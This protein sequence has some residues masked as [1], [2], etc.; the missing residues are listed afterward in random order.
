VS[1]TATFTEVAAAPLKRDILE[2][3]E[4]YVLPAA[5]QVFLWIGRKV[6]KEQRAKA[7]DLATVCEHAHTDARVGA[8]DVAWGHEE[9]RHLR[10]SC[11]TRPCCR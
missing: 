9:P 10:A 2:S 6:A 1:D 3:T 7:W 11:G 8:P 5:H 4:A